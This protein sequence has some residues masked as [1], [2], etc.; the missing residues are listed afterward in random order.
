M[1][2]IVFLPEAEQ[3][4]LDAVQYYESQAPGLG[5]DYLSELSGPFTP[6]QF[7]LKRGPS[8]KGTYTGG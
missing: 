6:F 8:L 1:K 4:M 7:L 2:P 5:L 3:E